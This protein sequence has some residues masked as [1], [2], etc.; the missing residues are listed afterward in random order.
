MPSIGEPSAG[1]SQ[2][3]SQTVLRCGWAF[4][5]GVGWGLWAVVCLSGFRER[6]GGW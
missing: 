5:F 1:I 3:Q 2:G 4:G 6:V